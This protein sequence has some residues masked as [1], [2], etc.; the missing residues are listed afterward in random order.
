MNKTLVQE[1]FGKTAASYLDLHRRTRNGASLER[2]VELTR[3]AEGLASARRRHRR[4]PRRLHLRAARRARLGDRHHPGNAR[5]GAGG[6]RTSAGL[7]N[8]RTAYAKAEALP[9]EDASFDLV[10]CR[11][12]PHRFDSI[13]E[14]PRPRSRRVLKPNGLVADRRQCGAGRHA[15]GDYV[16]AFERFRDPS[17]LRAWTMA[18]WRDALRRGRPRHRRTTSSSTSRWNPRAGPRATAPTMQAL[19]R[20]DAQ[21]QITPEVKAALEPEGAAGAEL[22]FRLCE[23]LFIAKKA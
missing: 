16:N 23:G 19:L 4:R 18:E 17:H 12:A 22:T 1:Q 6:S 15:S 2:L 13:P 9:F 10:T 21:A 7:T 20:A 3:P 11:I 14:F 5:H 8:L